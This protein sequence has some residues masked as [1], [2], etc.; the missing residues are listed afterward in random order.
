MPPA[1]PS[2]AARAENPTGLT[3]SG[4]GAAVVFCSYFGRHYGWRRRPADC[5]PF[6]VVHLLCVA[7]IARSR[8]AL[9]EWSGTVCAVRSAFSMCLTWQ[10]TQV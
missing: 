3:G 4:S 8:L 10:S 6:G 9:K 7:A 2:K 1:R 5:L